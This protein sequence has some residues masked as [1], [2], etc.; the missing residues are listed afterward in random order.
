MSPRKEH[1]YDNRALQTSKRRA[2]IRTN[3]LARGTA[4]VNLR[5][6]PPTL[7]REEVGALLADA[8]KALVA[9]QD[10]LVV[11]KLGTALAYLEKAELTSQ[12][13]ARELLAKV[14]AI[15]PEQET[16][17]FR[18]TTDEIEEIKR[19]ATGR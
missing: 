16:E 18:F 6:M 10:R 11:T 9:R 19:R 2:S 15:S 8:A 4:I 14:R 1:R 12:P 3:S 13:G 17:R 7:W 5:V